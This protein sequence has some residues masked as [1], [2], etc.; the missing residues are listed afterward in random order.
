M[1]LEWMI[2]KWL[3]PM[4]AQWNLDRPVGG[5]GLDVVLDVSQHADLIADL[6]ADLIADR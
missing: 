4:A 5:V 1:D 2:L 3:N 6:V